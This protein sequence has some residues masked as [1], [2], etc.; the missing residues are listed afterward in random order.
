MLRLEGLRQLK[1]SETS[2]G[3]RTRDIPDCS[4]VRQPTARTSYVTELLWQK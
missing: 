2:L 1:N 3:N 4:I